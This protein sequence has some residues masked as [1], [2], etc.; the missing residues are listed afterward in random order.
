M[1]NHVIFD[2]QHQQMHCKHCGAEKALPLAIPLLKAAE[3]MG[4]F[5]IQHSSCTPA[6]EREKRPDDPVI[7]SLEKARDTVVALCKPKGTE[8]AMDWVMSCPAKPDRDPDLVIT[9][10]LVMAELE[11]NRLR[12]YQAALLDS[13]RGA[14]R[15][16]AHAATDPLYSDA[17]EELDSAIYLVERKL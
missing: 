17:Y 14:R 8:G 9:G 15:A 2:A 10:A 1:T 4:E 12:K 3:K 16:L 6:A 11:I 5:V 13:A 7:Q